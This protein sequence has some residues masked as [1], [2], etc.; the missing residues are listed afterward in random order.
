[1]PPDP[2]KFLATLGLPPNRTRQ[3]LD[4]WEPAESRSLR[5]WSILQRLGPEASEEDW[6]VGGAANQLLR[7][8]LYSPLQLIAQ[9]CG[10]AA[11]KSMD[12]DYPFLFGFVGLL[13][14]VLI[15]L[16]G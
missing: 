8:G 3:V 2:T 4:S 6:P 7:W 11:K 9:E 10:D 12:T 5:V 16:R 14:H 15:R 1:M 13:T